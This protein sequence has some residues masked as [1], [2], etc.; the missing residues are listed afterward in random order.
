MHYDL[1]AKKNMKFNFSWTLKT[2]QLHKFIPES[3]LAQTVQLVIR[4]A[5]A[6]SSAVED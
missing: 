3:C 4:L 5:H 1:E 2:T 6:R